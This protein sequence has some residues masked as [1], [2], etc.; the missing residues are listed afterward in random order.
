MSW[1]DKEV[2]ICNDL[3]ATE[4]VWEYV[5]HMARV[6]RGLAEVAKHGSTICDADLDGLYAINCDGT[7]SGCMRQKALDN[8]S[9][10]AKEVL[11][12]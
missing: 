3:C 8:L 6:I 1:L 7:C 10:D 11:N 12:D 2:Q 9:P 4:E 5:Q